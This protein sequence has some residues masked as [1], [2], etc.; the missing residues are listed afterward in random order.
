MKI[1]KLT[2]ENITSF[3]GQHTVNFEK[4]NHEDLFAI[5]GPTGAGKSSLLT[6]ISL[7]LYGKSHKKTL[8]AVD[9]ITAGKPAASVILDF[10]IKGHLYRA[11]WKCKLQKKNGERLKNPQIQ[12]TLYL[13]H[14]AIEKTPEDILNLTF[15]QFTKTVIL[16]QGEF[17]RFLL[18][19]F[20]DRKIILEHLTNWDN[21]SHIYPN[22]KSALKSTQETI[23]QEEGLIA[24]LSLLTADKILEIK[25]RRPELTQL[26][27]ILRLYLGHLTSA[28]NNFHTFFLILEKCILLK[29]QEEEQDLAT[30]AAQKNYHKTSTDSAQ[31]CVQFENLQR[32]FSQALPRLQKALT[33][34][35]EISQYSEKIKN[36]EQRRLAEEH[37]MV[38]YT[39][40]LQKIL[41]TSAEIET[42]IEKLSANHQMDIWQ[43]SKEQDFAGKIKEYRNLINSQNVNAITCTNYLELLDSIK[44]KIK[45]AQN[46]ALEVQEE[47]NFHLT[48]DIDSLA[49]LNDQGESYLLELSQLK[50]HLLH[51][52]EL[53]ERRMKAEQRLQFLKLQLL[54]EEAQL[55][56]MHKARDLKKLEL[57]I[58]QCLAVAHK[59]GH[60]PVCLKTYETPSTTIKESPEIMPEHGPQQVELLQ[61][62]INA[63]KSTLEFEQAK[64]EE[65][66]ELVKVIEQ[67]VLSFTQ[68]YQL[69]TRDGDRDRD[70]DRN[71]EQLL[72]LAQEK[73]HAMKRQKELL[74][75]RIGKTKNLLER[76]RHLK[77][78]LAKLQTEEKAILTKIEVQQNAKSEMTKFL[79]QYSELFIQTLNIA[80]LPHQ[81]VI[82]FYEEL[83]V[84]GQQFD[85]ITHTLVKNRELQQNI[86]CFLETSKEKTHLLSTE[87]A[88]LRAR[89]TLLSQNFKDLQTT[90]N[91]AQEIQEQE[92]LLEKWRTRKE[93]IQR[94]LHLSEL[95]FHQAKNNRLNTQEK[96]LSH[97][98]D[99]AYYKKKLNEIKKQLQLVDDKS[100]HLAEE[101]LNK[102]SEL[103]LTLETSLDLTSTATSQQQ[104][105]T[106]KKS[107]ESSLHAAIDL[108]QRSIDKNNETLIQE[109]ILLDNHQH[110]LE[111]KKRMQN[112]L[113]NDLKKI[114]RWSKLLMVLGKNRDEFRNFA[115]SLIEEKLSE[116]ANIELE[117]L[118]EG[119]YKIQTQQTTLGT[120]YYIC[121]KYNGGELRK[122][123]TLSGGEIF[124]IS[125]AMALSLAELT[126]GRTEIDS[127]FID[128]GFGSLDDDAIEEVMGTLYA[129][130]SRG[131]QIGLISHVQKLTDRIPINF[132]LVKGQFGT[133]TVEMAYH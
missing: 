12:R 123:S 55:N 8:T 19:S 34:Q 63:T 109:K 98:E 27:Q 10:S 64:R 62:K 95:S 73:L 102:K 21:L 1:Q 36:R 47:N 45:A 35:R 50:Q 39:Q 112:R 18:S 104:I 42:S 90:E 87:L 118:C 2:L 41:A 132:N 129:I 49:K 85:T 122:I 97:N 100:T 82:N 32:D 44:K 46:C 25:Q 29:D 51:L 103:L 93:A 111:K 78:D 91:P 13:D 58:Q 79:K 83:A 133:S 69:V 17:S 120:D 110:N 119:R 127:F 67:K 74:E 70:R 38:A 26:L 54:E 124:L 105:Q 60:C 9:L 131:K 71:K 80:N 107:L 31:V 56:F 22:I 108:S 114:A 4:L 14:N 68:K 113:K 81:E 86:D 115:L 125:L 101:F 15:D 121:D 23:A 6:A 77:N 52:Q 16:N 106:A 20:N 92:A 94:E 40:K 72:S 37:S 61:Q 84:K 28:R 130:K 128:E 117:N 53:A 3:S 57:S 43:Q 126:R 88:E 33:I 30:L 11:I 89:Q 96:R 48:E 65:S 76:S 5:T 7:A 24:G 116:Q 59:D 75:A 99:L 66:L